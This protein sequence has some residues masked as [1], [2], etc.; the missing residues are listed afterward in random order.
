MIVL[1]VVFY[2]RISSG[3]PDASRDLDSNPFRP[4][5]TNTPGP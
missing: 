1:S 4:P 3:A 5:D 2:S